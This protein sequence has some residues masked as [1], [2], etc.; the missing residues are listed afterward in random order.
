LSLCTFYVEA[1]STYCNRYFLNSGAPKDSPYF[2][3]ISYDETGTRFS[4][5]R[6][7]GTSLEP[8]VGNL[9]GDGAIPRN[10]TDRAA[11][12]LA[13]M[14]N[15]YF[16]LLHTW[17]P[18]IGR[19]CYMSEQG[20]ISVYPWVPST[21][22]RYTPALR[23]AE[24][25]AAVLP[26]N[27]PNRS[28]V[29]TGVYPDSAGARISLSGPIY[30]GG[31][32]R[33]ALSLDFT[34]AALS[35]LL[36]GGYSAFL[37][38]EAYNVVASDSF[39]ADGQQTRGLSTHVRL[40]ARGL[41]ALQEAEFGKLQSAG[42]YLVYKARLAEAPFTLIVLTP[43]TRPILSAAVQTLPV[44]LIG[45]M[46]VFTVMAAIKLRRVRDEL[47]I[48]S[49]TD[50][51]TGLR[52]RHFLNAV[53]ETELSRAERYHQNLS[54]IS[55]DLDRF[56]RIN[57]LY[58][59]P[60]GDEVLITTARIARETIRE[61]DILVRMGG[62]EFMIL[63]TNTGLGAAL[64]V[65]DRLRQNLAA[66]AHPI[67]GKITASFGVV[68]KRA[69]EDYTSLYSR[70][71]EALYQAKE[72]GR[73]CVRTYKEDASIGEL[74][75]KLEWK[76]DWECGEETIDEQHRGLSRLL[77]RLLKTDPEGTEG[78]LDELEHRLK[79]HFDYEERVLDRVGFPELERHRA[80]HKRLLEKFAGQRQ[81]IMEGA[82]TPLALFTYAVE[83]VV[84]GHLLEED[85]KFFPYLKK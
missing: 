83:E 66:E 51:L 75:L 49:F 31:T 24:F 46:L 61:S 3:L 32:L 39:S 48:A 85:T 23:D 20:F 57:D 21:E 26:E 38:D 56:K 72:D 55:F 43:Q 47:R 34:T 45:A 16:R 82:L 84:V 71:D 41:A 22:F 8:M 74:V 60:V 9:T 52:N 35:T 36:Q 4:M 15:D 54:I 19:S 42:G 6:A 25:Y 58:G 12:N 59:H 30:Y 1:L 65:A 81:M 73:N 70:V 79:E 67:A 28:L 68:E 53:I 77:N 14:L 80:E 18:E 69:G 11:F 40:S 5:D 17:M 50:A 33:G 63:L 64:R 37:V 7:G 62:E 78:Y 76:K 13:L 44:A 29:W 10:A 27:N 2:T